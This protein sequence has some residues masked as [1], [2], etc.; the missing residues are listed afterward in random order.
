[1]NTIKAWFQSKGGFAHVVAVAFAAAMLAY[2]AVPQFHDLVH[3]IN[4]AFPAGLEQ[5]VG[6]IIAL[7]VWY[8]NNQTPESQVPPQAVKGKDFKVIS[9]LAVAFLLLATQAS[10][11]SGVTFTGTTEVTALHFNGAWGPANHTT[12]SLDLIDWGPTK[13]NS[14]SV[15][16]HQV[17]APSANLSAYMGGVKFVPDLSSLISKTNLSSDQLGVFLQAAAGEGSLPAKNSLAFFIGGGVNYRMT[18]NLSFST[19][20]FRIGRAGSQAYYEVS[21]GIQYIFNPQ[22]AKA[23]SAK[24]FLAR[25]AAVSRAAAAIR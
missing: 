8:K 24:R 4:A 14:L 23:A 16:G 10:A 21:S 15:E 2:A 6:T 13:A 18:S 12:E 1:M 19:I 3:T 17:V 20:D 7:A 9:L 5:L 25:R 11:Q 22:V